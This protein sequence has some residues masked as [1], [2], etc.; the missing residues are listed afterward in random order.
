MKPVYTHTAAAPNGSVKVRVIATDV[1]ESRG[2]T[3][4]VAS[5]PHP[6]NPVN[7]AV[8]FATPDLTE[9][10]LGTLT[11]LPVFSSI[12]I[13]VYPGA[14]GGSYDTKA[15]AKRNADGHRCGLVEL[16]FDGETLVESVIVPRSEWES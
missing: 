13:N 11:A 6:S 8:F 5:E 2:W 10:D 3:T 7:E 14:I 15:D 16:I 1:M 12:F 4:L 9:C